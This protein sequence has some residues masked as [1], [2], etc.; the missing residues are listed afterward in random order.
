M[1]R[2]PGK[3]AVTFVFSVVLIDV[4]G[5]GIIIPV[6]PA[7]LLELT[8]EPLSEVVLYGGGLLFVYALM[9][10]FFAPIL[11]SLSDRYGRRPV[12]LFSLFAY[13]VDYII[14]GLAPTLLWLFIGRTLAGIAGSTHTPAMAYIADITPPEKRAQSFGLIGAAFGLGFVIGPALGGLL[15]EIGPRVPFFVAAGLAF[16]ATIYG[17]F[18]LPET[19]AREDRRPFD[20]ARANPVG[21][22]THLRHTPL[23][24]GLGAAIIFY[25]MAHDANPAVWS[26]YTMLKFDWSPSDIGLSLA[27]VGLMIAFVQGYLTRVAIPRL[28]EKGAVILGIS[29]ASIG[30]VGFAFASSGWVLYAWLA[31]W[32]LMGLAMPA[33]RSIMSARVGANEQGELQGAIA[34]LISLTMI[35]APLIMTWLF[36]AYT[37]DTAPVYFPG[38]PF[39]AAAGMMAISLGLFLMVMRKFGSL[40]GSKTS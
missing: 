25:Q 39:L 18:V 3:H 27:F 34:S 6:L 35:I 38:A 8:G 24:L 17:Y 12:L 36:R 37:A 5:F 4:I 30:F 16:L 13:G 2:E 7:L 26:Y 32:A 33:I 40:E 14:A 23:I 9:Q 11:G 31:P 15:G 20:F 10:F 21:A 19:L 22:W 29:C 28:G 1:T